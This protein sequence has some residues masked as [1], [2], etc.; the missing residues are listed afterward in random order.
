MIEVILG[1]IALVFFALELI[2]AVFALIY[3]KSQEKEP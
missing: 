3:F 2:F 1:S